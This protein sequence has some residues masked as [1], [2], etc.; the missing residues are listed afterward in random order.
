M[1]IFSSKCDTHVQLLLAQ[2][3]EEEL[4]LALHHGHQWVQLY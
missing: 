3:S 2:R 1:E 4:P